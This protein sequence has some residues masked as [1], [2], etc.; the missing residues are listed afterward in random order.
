MVLPIFVYGSPVLRKVSEDIPQDYP[1]LKSFLEDMWETMYKSDGVGLAAPQVGRNIRL[2]VIDGSGMSDDDPT[3]VDFRKAFI[4]P[5]IIQSDGTPWVF[6]EG[7]L[8]LPNIRE[9]ISRNAKIIIE[10][11]DE[12]FNFFREEY[13][14]LKARI[15]QHEYD[16]LEGILLVD[17]ISAIK[18]KL[19]AGKLN[20]ISK[21]KVDVSY[22]IKALK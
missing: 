3:M 22:K 15:I 6:N 19:L 7:C 11:Y 17:H 5:R 16:H 1:N 18:R 10:Y 13:D 12:N 2:F 20:A 4:N 14:G 21:G 8:S 9:D